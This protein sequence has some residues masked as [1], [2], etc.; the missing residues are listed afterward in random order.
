MRQS[1]LAQEHSRDQLHVME[2]EGE[3]MKRMMMY[4]LLGN[5]L[6]PFCFVDCEAWRCPYSIVNS[7]HHHCYRFLANYK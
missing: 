5:P 7:A 4:Y 2:E 6:P 1:G 3:M